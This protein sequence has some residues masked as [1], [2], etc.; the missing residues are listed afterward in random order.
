[1]EIFVHT[2]KRKRDKYVEGASYIL[3]PVHGYKIFIEDRLEEWRSGCGGPG[4]TTG[5]VTRDGAP[6]NVKQ[7]YGTM[8]YFVRTNAEHIL[9]QF[10]KEIKSFNTFSNADGNMEVT[11]TS[12][13]DLRLKGISCISEADGKHMQRIFSVQELLENPADEAVAAL[14]RFLSNSEPPQTVP[15][16]RKQPELPAQPKQPKPPKPPTQQEPP[17]Q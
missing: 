4:V 12:G 15:R 13:Q 7:I 9:V 5:L 11:D 16:K 3:N 2:D 14:V 6:I 8:P 1:M 17:T 10:D